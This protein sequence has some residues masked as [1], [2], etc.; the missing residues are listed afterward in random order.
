VIDSEQLGELDIWLGLQVRTRLLWIVRVEFEVGVVVRASV[1]GAD[2]EA[3]DGVFWPGRPFE[4]GGVPVVRGGVVDLGRST[5][6]PPS[7]TMMIR[8]RATIVM[9]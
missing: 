9:R 6:T 3:E 1:A 5:T 2:D 7:S 8:T 4:M